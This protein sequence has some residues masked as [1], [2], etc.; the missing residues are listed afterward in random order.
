MHTRLYTIII[1]G[2]KD[3][4][5]ETL[6]GVLVLNA[7]PEVSIEVILLDNTSDG[8][9]RN[10]VERAIA[11][12]P[13]D[14]SVRYRHVSAPGKAAAQNL[15]I[16]DARGDYLVFLDDDVLPEPDLVLAYDQAFQSHAC[17][18]IQGRVT[19][20]FEDGAVAPSWL[21]A[22]FRL[23]LAEMDFGRPIIP[24]EMGLTGANMALRAAMFREH[25]RFD[26]RLG[27]G[28]SGTLEDQEYSERL[29]ARGDVQLFW[30]AASVR[31]RIP[32]A[33]L[34]PRAF[35]GI[36][37][38]VGHSD[39]F[40]SGHYIVGGRLRFTLYTLKRLLLGLGPLAWA[41]LRADRAAALLAL[42]ERCRDVGY[43]RQGWRQLG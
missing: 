8:R 17:G 18:A 9:H 21:N 7:S 16:E 11:E 2:Y 4:V 34:R 19:L 20:Q 30:P 28:R 22:R 13:V 31:H 6:A 15:G 24:F 38:D 41:L 36:Y 35:M 32:P 14:R 1:A 37:F 39:F 5:R 42:C 25:G 26:E 3:T 12:A 27:P 23:D 29:R 40:L 33:R 43:W 10:L